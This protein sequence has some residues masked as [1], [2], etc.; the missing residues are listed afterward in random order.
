MVFDNS[1]PDGTPGILLGFL[2]GDEARRLG[3]AGPDDRRKAVLTLRALL[4]AQAAH[5]VD[6]VGAR[7]A[8]RAVEWRV[9]TA[10]CSGPTSG[11][12]TALRF[13]SR[14]GRLHWAGTETASV[15]SGL[16]G[17]GGVVGPARAATEVLAALG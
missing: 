1:P 7:L 11:P 5:P 13:A 8:G 4:R 10:R 17:R 2:E 3:R 14:S 6:F 9:A 12:A 15:W 16:H